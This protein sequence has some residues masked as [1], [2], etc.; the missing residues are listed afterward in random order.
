MILKR[1]TLERKSVILL[2]GLEFYRIRINALSNIELRG[3]HT[4]V[5]VEEEREWS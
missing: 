5:T 4:L 1:P 3:T 2:Y